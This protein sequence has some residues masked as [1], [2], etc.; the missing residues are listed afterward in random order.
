LAKNITKSPNDARAPGLAEFAKSNGI[1]IPLELI[2]EKNNIS[3]S[4]VSGSPTISSI[5]VRIVVRDALLASASFSRHLGT[6]ADHETRA[7]GCRAALP[8]PPAYRLFAFSF[9]F[10]FFFFSLPPLPRPRLRFF[11]TTT[12]E[13]GATT[14]L[15]HIVLLWRR[16]RLAVR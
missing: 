2:P 4:V 12:V 7:P 9:V 6:V 15:L 11:F 3:K 10:F 1:K 14:F 5:V 16:R 8:A 13:F